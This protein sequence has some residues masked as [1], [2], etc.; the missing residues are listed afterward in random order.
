M[1]SFQWV[2]DKIYGVVEILSTEEIH[3]FIH[4]TSSM[5]GLVLTPLM[6]L[7]FGKIHDEQL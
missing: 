2:S 1:S 6:M 4:M 7:L 3:E 5:D